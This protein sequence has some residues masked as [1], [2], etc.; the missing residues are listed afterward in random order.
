L[1]L[2]ATLPILFY[3]ATVQ[4]FALTFTTKFVVI[5]LIIATSITVNLYFRKEKTEELKNRQILYL[6]IALLISGFIFSWHFFQLDL[7]LIRG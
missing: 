3:V 7:N 5:A 6:F 2:L 4:Q 1:K